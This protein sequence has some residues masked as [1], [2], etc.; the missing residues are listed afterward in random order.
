MRGVSVPGSLCMLYIGGSEWSE[1]VELPEK[2]DNRVESPLGGIDRTVS[3]CR[4]GGGC[5]GRRSRGV[6]HRREISYPF[7]LRPLHDLSQLSGIEPV[8]VI[9]AAVYNDTASTL[10]VDALHDLPALGALFVADLP[11]AYEGVVFDLVEEAEIVALRWRDLPLHDLLDLS[12]IEKYPLAAV[13]PL[14][15]ELLL[16]VDEVGLQRDVAVGAGA[17]GVFVD[18][19]ALLEIDTVSAVAVGADDTL[20]RCA[21]VETFVSA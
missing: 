3:S 16:F 7:Q 21:A 20:D 10:V 14:D 4:S 15:I 9:G 12:E 1:A 2:T 8:A 13:A 17:I 11:F 19:E 18:F 5:G 6:L